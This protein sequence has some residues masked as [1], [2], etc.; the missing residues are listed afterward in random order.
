MRVKLQN[1]R[2]AFPNL[3]KPNAIKG[4]DPKFS[5]TFIIDPTTERGKQN[6]K[7][8][9]DALSDVAK[10]KWGDKAKDV[11]DVLKTQRRVCF[12]DGADKKNYNGFE[13]KWYVSATDAKKP[14]II[15]RNRTELGI[16]DGKPYAGC[17][18]NA[19]I[20]LW[21]QDNDYGR[22]INASLSGVQFVRD[23]EHFS[24]SG[25]AFVEDFDD[26]SDFE[27]DDG[28]DLV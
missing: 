8:L 2:L 5:A 6:M 22:R 18:V 15:D 1:V 3:F 25:P 12:R 17:Y 7:V 16:A 9:E 24:G 28:G 27:D 21:A 23:G 10:D 14:L 26:L 19:T 4:S 11:L 20:D 13:G